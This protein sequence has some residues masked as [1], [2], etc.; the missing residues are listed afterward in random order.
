[1]LNFKP[2]Q[3][4]PSTLVTGLV[5]HLRNQAQV[6][7]VGLGR[8]IEKLAYVEIPVEILLYLRCSVGLPVENP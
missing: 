2:C 7:R 1:M 3:I 6:A 8:G 5:L 4:M